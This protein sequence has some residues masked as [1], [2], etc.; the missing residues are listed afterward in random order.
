MKETSCISDSL[1]MR[2]VNKKFID[3][4]HKMKTAEGI[5]M[6]LWTFIEHLT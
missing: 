1:K 6:K 3:C 4:L 2:G 5:S